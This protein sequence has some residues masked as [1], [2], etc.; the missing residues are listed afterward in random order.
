MAVCMAG[1][2]GAWPGTEQLL[3]P[4]TGVVERGTGLLTLDGT[5]A[6]EGLSLAWSQ[7]CMRLT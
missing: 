2:T 7:H 1:R 4:V 5:L 3:P 6:A